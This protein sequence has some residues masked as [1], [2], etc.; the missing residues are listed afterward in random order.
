VN[1][2]DDPA[3]IKA[4]WLAIR[5]QVPTCGLW[6]YPAFLYWA[7][8]QSTEGVPL[9]I[10]EWGVPKPTVP[11]VVW[12]MT[13]KAEV[14]GIP[15][16]ADLD[17]FMGSAAA[18]VDLFGDH[19]PAAVAPAAQPP[20]VA[21]APTPT[22]KGYWLVDGEGQVYTFGDATYHGNPAHLNKPVVSISGTPTGRGYHLFCADYG[23]FTFGDAR[24][25]GAGH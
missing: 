24:F 1:E 5:E 10:D 22:G 16:L 2:G 23:V 25:E 14:P 12:G 15:A 17:A 11:C 4:F 6:T 13:D 21:G 3:A 9:A 20:C 18:Y 7:G 19:K 8:I